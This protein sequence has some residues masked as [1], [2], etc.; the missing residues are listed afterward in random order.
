MMQGYVIYFVKQ[1]LKQEYAG[2]SGNE[3]KNLRLSGVEVC[4]VGH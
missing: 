4:L 3:I 2:L 1:K